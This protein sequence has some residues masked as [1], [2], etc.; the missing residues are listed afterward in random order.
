MDNSDKIRRLQRVMQKQ[1][2]FSVRLMTSYLCPQRCDYCHIFTE[3]EQQFDKPSNMKSEIAC[4]ALDTYFELMK[5]GKDSRLAVSFYGGEPLLNW[6][7]LRHTLSYGNRRFGSQHVTWILNTNGTLLTPE[8]ARF[9]K[10]HRVDVH[11]GV[12][13]P[14]KLNNQYRKFSNGKLSHER[15]MKALAILADCHYTLQFDSCLTDANVHDLKGLVDLAG[16]YGA[17]RIYLAIPDHLPGKKDYTRDDI[18]GAKKIAEAGAYARG[19]NIQLAGPWKTALFAA[20]SEERDFERI[21]HLVIDTTGLMYF[22]PYMDNPIGHI[23]AFQDVVFSNHYDS[24][25]SRWNETKTA[26]DGCELTRSCHSYLM[27]MVMYHTGAKDG[28]ERECQLAKH[29]LDHFPEIYG[30]TG[31]FSSGTR[32]KWSQFMRAGEGYDDVTRNYVYH[33]VNQS[34]V[35]N[36]R[37]TLF[38]ILDLFKI[39]ANPNNV[40]NAKQSP[41]FWP[42]VIELMDTGLLIPEELDESLL[43][44]QRVHD[45]E[46]RQRLETPAFVFYYSKGMEDAMVHHRKLVEVAYERLLKTGLPVPE[47]KVLLYFAANQ[48]EL[49]RFW[50]NTTLPRWVHSFVTF[51]RL[52]VVNIERRIPDERQPE[53]IRSMK[54]ELTHIFLGQFDVNIP[55]WLVEG[56][57]EYFARPYYHEN[58][59]KDVR[60]SQIYTFR[61]LELFVETN[62]LDVDASPIFEN[63]CYKQ[64]HSFVHYL[65]NIQGEQSLLECITSTSFE[66]DFRS[67]FRQWYGR[68]LDSAEKK[69]FRTLSGF[70]G[71]PSYRNIVPS[72]HLHVISKNGQALFFNAVFG[73]NLV[74]STDLLKLLKFIKNGKPSA[75]IL[76]KYDAEDLDSALSDVY[77]AKLVVYENDSETREDVPASHSEHVQSGALI[78]NLRLNLT[79]NCNMACTYCYVIHKNHDTTLMDWET[80]RKA[81][82]YFFKLQRQHDHKSATIRFFGGEPLLN[83]KVLKQALQ[84]SEEIRGD[85]HVNYFLNTNG[86]LLTEETVKELA[87][88]QVDIIISLDGIKKNHDTFRQLKTTGSSFDLTENAIDLCLMNHC[89][90]SID[91]TLGDHNYDN[92]KEF[93]DYL[94]AR[95]EKFGH[96]LFLGLQNMTVGYQDEQDTGALHQKVEKLVAACRYAS[97]R[98]LQVGGLA[99]FPYSRIFNQEHA[100]RYCHAAGRELSVNPDGNIYPCGALEIQL[101]SIDEMD[102][103]CQKEPYLNLAR[104]GIGT[105]PACEGCEIEVFCAGGCI[106]DAACDSNIFR[107]TK[108]CDFEKAFFRA[109]VQEFL[110]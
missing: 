47:K 24:M 80:A 27:N 68:S 11:I 64:A 91:T 31:T 32:L 85:I 23:H 18:L 33:Y 93:I 7:M 49:R 8:R 55:V 67:Q 35:S 26:C 36:Q 104:R 1:R 9:L 50:G 45:L 39:P 102:T 20:G 66:K 86:T 74:C 82:S 42:T 88:C 96:P 105:I 37:G 4:S 46:D 106:A 81:I 62:F 22:G 13:G 84:Y 65:V 71:R 43:Y 41:D 51:R 70:L 92:L 63:M 110:L 73:D 109:M 69:W 38:Q 77:R 101:G 58:F 14:S 15:V 56:L 19:Q 17:D 48:N 75:A 53:Y 100:G 59:K 108:N 103:I 28:C 76:N 83:W 29:I 30:G 94:V 60:A 87:R 34:S 99:T 21:P 54:H 79:R 25:M 57:C 90:V 12:D 97:D 95:S 6:E 2:L 107:P 3:K 5:N 89:H 10:E 98:G 52:L 72:R 61:E 16:K 44:L 40:Y 78:N